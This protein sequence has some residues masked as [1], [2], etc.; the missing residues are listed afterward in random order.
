MVQVVLIFSQVWLVA[1][2]CR[3]K[4]V[5]L[6]VRVVMVMHDARAVVCALVYIDIY[7]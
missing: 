1:F 7:I 6:A 3:G 2:P 4:H 5:E